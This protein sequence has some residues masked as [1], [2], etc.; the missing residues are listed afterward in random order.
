VISRR[1]ESNRPLDFKLWRASMQVGRS[2]LTL[3]TGVP[4]QSVVM[5]GRPSNRADGRYNR[6]K[7]QLCCSSAHDLDL[8]CASMEAYICVCKASLTHLYS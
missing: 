7:T 4:L 2:L 5:K 3:C 6:V 1:R 8:I